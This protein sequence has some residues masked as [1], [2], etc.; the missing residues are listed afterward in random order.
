[1]ECDNSLKFCLQDMEMEY[2][3]VWRVS[4]KSK[5]TISGNESRGVCGF[6]ENI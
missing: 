1:M 4:R 5:V 2:N 6:R 3:R